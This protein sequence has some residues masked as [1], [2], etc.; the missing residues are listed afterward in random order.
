MATT[1]PIALHGQVAIVT[2]AA[3]GI[4]RAIATTLASHGASIL[5]T[6][7]SAEAR[8][9]DELVSEIEA[10]GG[11]AHACC[12]DISRRAEV[13][14]F[15]QSA[16][17][18]FGRIDVLVNNAGIHS[19]PAPLLTATEADWDRLFAVN[20][21][22]VLFAC[23]AAVPHMRA[24][25]AGSVINIAS[26]SAFDVIADEGGYGISKIAVVRMAS[27]LAKELAGTGVRVNSLAPGWVRTRLTAEFF[28]EPVS[29]QE[30]LQTLPARRVAEP[31]EIA[32]VVLFLASALSSYVNGHCIVVD[33]GRVAGL[34]A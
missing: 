11:R 3:R 18:T 16:I 6:D 31:D 28:V 10:Q 24:R 30:I 2:G 15:V 33:G 19:Y 9:L 13:D 1:N 29:T 27:Y 14:A 22:G 7:L 5:A 20:V 26:D 4:G 21:K 25:G 32:H 12:A 34:P 17:D 23:Q 8:L